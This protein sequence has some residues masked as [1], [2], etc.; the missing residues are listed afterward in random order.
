MV[1]FSVPMK[2][3]F[4]ATAALLIA[5]AGLVLLVY[6]RQ[7]RMLYLPAKAIERTPQAIGLD[8][9]EVMLRTKDGVTIVAWHVPAK[10]ARRTLL[11]CHG[12]AGNI[13]HRLDSIRLFN[14]LGLN[15]LI[16]DYRGYGR[17]E[18]RPSEEGTYLDAEAAWDYL[19]QR[20]GVPPEEIILFGRSLGGAVAAEL[21]LRKS[22]AA[23]IVES[24]FTSVADMGQT[25]YPWLPVRL[26]AKHRYETAKKIPNIRCPKLVVHSPDDEIVP[27]EQGLALYEKA[28]PPKEL[29]AI[30]GGHSEGFLLSGAL[31]IEG[32]RK[33]IT[34]AV[35]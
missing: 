7:D 33:F 26:L 28:A 13:S 15:V 1:Q 17:S 35:K 19:T 6:F 25:H 11:F 9:V 24:S 4:A 30:S 23:L 14:S 18:G 5:Y 29:L 31:Y 12:N 34:T 20:R 22:P 3:L 16:F 21:A 2:T 32:L 27:Y 10:G 8:Y